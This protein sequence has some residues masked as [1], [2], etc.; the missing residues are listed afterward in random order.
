MSGCVVFH[1]SSWCCSVADSKNG[2]DDAPKET[3]V[4]RHS[5]IVGTVW[6]QVGNRSIH[7]K[8]TASV[9]RLNAYLEEGLPDIHGKND[10]AAP[11]LQKKR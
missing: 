11:K 5:T 8:R 7:R 1:A 10:G 6:S 2:L 4:M 9:F 3:L